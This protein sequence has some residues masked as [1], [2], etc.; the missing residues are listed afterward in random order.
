MIKS[1]LFNPEKCKHM[2]ISR[3]RSNTLSPPTFTL[4]MSHI[5]TTHVYKYL[6]IS[7]T[8]NLSWSQHISLICTKAMRLLGL[9]YRKF[10][11]HSNTSILLKLYVSLVRPLLEYACQVWNPYLLRD[12]NKVENVQKFA[13]RLC[14]KQW[15]LHYDS[16]LFVCELPLLATRRKY[17]NLCIYDVQNH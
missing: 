16:L 6:G 8:S 14:T 4:G 17:F 12:I 15:D 2:L 11:F 5:E 7:I 10:Y 1:L 13:L 3:K 9:I